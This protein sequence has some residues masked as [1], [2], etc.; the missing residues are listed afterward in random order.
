MNKISVRNYIVTMT[1][2]L[3]AGAAI[4]LTA[5]NVS[6]ANPK[7]LSGVVQTGGTTSS[8]PLPSVHVTLFEATQALPITL[9]ET[10]TDASGRFTIP[11]TKS[12]SASIFFVKADIG[13][14]VEFITVLGPNLPAS[15]TIN[16]LTTVAA[17]YS[18][19]QFL[20]TGVISGNSFALQL[21]AG[22]YDNI[23]AF[24]TGQSSPVL[25][26]SPNADQTNSL[27]STR[28]L[29]N[30]LAACVNDPGVTAS[31][32]ALTTPPGGLP[33]HNTAEALANLARDPGQNVAGIFALALLSDLY[34]PPLVVIPDAWT[35]TV[36]V[37][38]SGDDNI[39]FGGPGNLAFDHRGYAWVTNNVPQG[40][41]TSSQY[42]MALKPNGKPADGR[43]GTPR[44]PL[45][46]G[47]ILGTGFGVTVDPGG[48]VWFGNFGWGTCSGCDPSP[49][50]NG[51]LSR[52]TLSGAAMSQPNG[53]QGG[54]VRAQ[55]LAADAEGNIWISSYGNDSVYV[56]LRGNP[57]QSVGFQQYEN[58][59]PFDVAIAADG[60]AWVSNSGG[61]LGGHDASV[62]KYALVNGALEQRFLH[63]LG[64]AAIKAMSLDS[65]GNAWVASLAN[66]WVYAFRPDGIEIGHFSGGGMDSPWSMAVDGENNV[67][68][69]N[70]GPL[71]PTSPPF[72][73]RLTK[74]W[75]VDAP[76]GRNVGDPISPPTG[77]T[78][79]S[80]G[81]EVLL[82]NGDPLYG[83][84]APPSFI[85]M[86]R[87][88]NV[89]IDQAGNI[90]SINNWK[91]DAAIDFLVNPGG[92]G[93]VIFV[94]LAAPPTTQIH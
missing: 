35:V 5:H 13:E 39:L 66:S 41:T 14:G 43:N 87:Q 80:A 79:P 55:G 61:L 81:S 23:V 53:Y 38:D 18:M 56:F 52:F 63:P 22:M 33:P 6:S 36:K 88:T 70:F 40:Q 64:H 69:A 54:P 3:F 65:H 78:V 89:V 51:S 12:S 34:A 16:E 11:Y 90:W 30:L 4:L 27:R 31:L 94:G 92:D 8:Q 45:T 20:R 46:G 25:L 9:G 62:A 86:M 28:S 49:D 93:I 68:V 7:S 76:P 19:A 24:A 73:G 21:A 17:N 71:D 82:H 74:L 15:V 67:W 1:S 50:G 42:V 85:P 10:T 75:G 57:H 2:M 29:A 47:G 72:T 26:N 60:T 59:G 83:P 37:N 48:S 32:F 44:S 91:P 77:Y 58:S 84:G